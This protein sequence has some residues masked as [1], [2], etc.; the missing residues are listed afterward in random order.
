MSETRLAIFWLVITAV[1]WSTGGVFIKFIEW[2]PLAITGF[3]SLIAVVFIMFYLQRK[4]VFTWSRYQIGAAICYVGAVV[5]FV[6]ATKLTTAANAILLQYTTPVYVALLAPLFLGEATTR[7]DWLFM[8]LVLM[9]ISLFFVDQLSP[10][11]LQGNLIALGSGICVAGM[12]IFMRKQKDGSTFESVILGNCATVLVCLPAFSAPW[13]SMEGWAALLFLGAVQ[14]GLGYYF[15][16]KAVV[17]VSAL[18]VSVITTLEPI[19]N[20]VWVMLAMGETPSFW[21]FC[22]GLIVL[23]SITTWGVLKAKTGRT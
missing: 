19:L 6:T 1:L 10:E 20:P 22:G 7:R 13:P 15:Y 9:G 5:G 16:C 3:R 21:A 14:L 8:I 2:S 17:K 4:P 18:E 12:H 11:G 23:G